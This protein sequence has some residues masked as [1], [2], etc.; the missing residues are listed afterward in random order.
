MINRI[1]Y[2][3]DDAEL[4]EDKKYKMKTIFSED[5]ILNHKNITRCS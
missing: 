1:M 5:D 4:P 3:E 2:D